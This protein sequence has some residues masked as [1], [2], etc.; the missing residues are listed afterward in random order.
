MTDGVDFD[1]QHFSRLE[2]YADTRLGK[3]LQRPLSA[4]LTWF[5]DRN[6]SRADPVDDRASARR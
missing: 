6:G 5:R 3:T 2:T 1:L 4:A